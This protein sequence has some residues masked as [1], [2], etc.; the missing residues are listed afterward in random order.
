MK[1]ESMFKIRSLVA[2]ALFASAALSTAVA[3]PNTRLYDAVAG[4]DTVIDL[5]ICSRNVNLDVAGSGNT[6]LDFYVYNSAGVE[7]FSEEA[8]SD[9]MSGLFT[10]NFEGCATYT[11]HVFNNGGAPNRFVVRLTDA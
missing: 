5:T 6:N 3:A 4:Q 1:E 7:I 2:G 11:L 10:Q 8:T 9:W